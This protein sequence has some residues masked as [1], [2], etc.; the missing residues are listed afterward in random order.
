[1]EILIFK[2]FVPL[3]RFKLKYTQFYEIKLFLRCGLAIEPA[4][5]FRLLV[6][7][8]SIVWLPFLDRPSVPTPSLPPTYLATTPREVFLK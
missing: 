1:M 5:C 8:L 3:I 2:C 7:V 4:Q 6:D